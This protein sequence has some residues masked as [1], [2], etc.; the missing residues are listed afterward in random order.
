MAKKITV[1]VEVSPENISAL[2][3]L[4]LIKENYRNAMS[5]NSA[6]SDNVK[7]LFEHALTLEVA[8]KLRLDMQFEQDIRHAKR[9]I[10]M[11]QGLD[12]AIENV[13]LVSA[14]NSSETKY[15][16]SIRSKL[17]KDKEIR[18]KLKKN[19]KLVQQESRK[20]YD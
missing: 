5:L 14:H 13:K 12:T 9:F 8:M 2:A 4:G 15:F 17:R 10:D 16:D 7:N 18:K 6:I 11:G 3:H 19:E 20:F 1:A